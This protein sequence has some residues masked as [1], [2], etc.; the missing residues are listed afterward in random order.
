MDY[1]L[2]GIRIRDQRLKQKLTQEKLS[3]L[4]GISDAFMGFIE[5]GERKLSIETLVKVAN[6]LG[7]TVDN[8]LTN[9]I[10]VESDLFLKEIAHLTN[11]C[12]DGQKEAI[13]D[14]V[15]AL[16]PHLHKDM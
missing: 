15:K 1:K 10:N 7:I 12:S 3:E 6:A 2:L 13:L 9:S 16:T 11:N 14:V 5:R 4:V 8:L